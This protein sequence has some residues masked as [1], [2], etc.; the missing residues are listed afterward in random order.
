MHGGL[1][2]R[3]LQRTGGYIVVLVCLYWSMYVLEDICVGLWE[4][5]VN[6]MGVLVLGGFYAL[7]RGC[8]LR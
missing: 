5:G 2:K 7:W 8:E 4:C 3:V 6:M 1:W